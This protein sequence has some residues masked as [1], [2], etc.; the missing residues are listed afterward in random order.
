MD[1][2]ASTSCLHAVGEV[3]AAAGA[4]SCEVVD[5]VDVGTVADGADPVDGPRHHAPADRA[6]Q[7]RA[8]PQRRC[9]RRPA[10]R[11]GRL[12]APPSPGAA[13]LPRPRAGPRRSGRSARA[14]VVPSRAPAQ[15]SPASA[16]R[17]AGTADRRSSGPHAAEGAASGRTP[18]PRI[19]SP[20]AADSRRDRPPAR[21]PPGRRGRSRSGGSSARSRPDRQGC[22]RARSFRRRCPVRPRRA[23]RGAPAAPTPRSRRHAPERSRPARRWKARS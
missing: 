15:G 12:R 7:A 19:G 23:P 17:R 3:A 9:R 22:D 8:V 4:A 20:G 13:A 11:S 1:V 6:R 2:S 18:R 14:E 16:A 21:C 5:G 10:F